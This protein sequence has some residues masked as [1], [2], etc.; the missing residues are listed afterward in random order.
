MKWTTT[1]LCLN[2]IFHYSNEIYKVNNPKFP[3]VSIEL[4][5][6]DWKS[7]GVV[8]ILISRGML[9]LMIVAMMIH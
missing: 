5:N 2:I 9:N 6:K 8:P 7:F 1:N 4:S 3:F